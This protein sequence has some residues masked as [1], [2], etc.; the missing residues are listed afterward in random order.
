MRFSLALKKR[1]AILKFLINIEL[2]RTKEVLHGAKK[3]NTDISLP[4]AA[5]G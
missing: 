3:N 4:A 1:V 5:K 2:T